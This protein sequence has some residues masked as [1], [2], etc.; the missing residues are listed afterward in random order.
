MSERRELRSALESYY[1]SLSPILLAIEEEDYYASIIQ[2]GD[3]NDPTPDVQDA[4]VIMWEHN[5][6]LVVKMVM[7]MGKELEGLPQ[8]DAIAYGNLGLRRAVWKYKPGFDNKFS[9]YARWWI[10]KEIRDAINTKGNLSGYI[11]IPAFPS[12]IPTKVGIYHFK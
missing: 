2:A 8:M 6:R 7:S 9:T 1:K 11:S 4:V 5:L 12:V 3:E 10:L